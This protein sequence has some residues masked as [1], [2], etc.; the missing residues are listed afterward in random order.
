[1]KKIRVLTLS[2]PYVSAAYRQKLRF[3]AED[4]RFEIGLI[5]PKQWAGQVFEPHPE[6]SYW[7]RTLD[8]A[9]DGKNHF[10]FYRGLDQAVKEF[11]PDI[12]NIEEE[13]YSYVTWQ[14]LRLAR[15]YH[16]KPL[17]YTWQNIH[18][19]YPF[20][21]SAIERAVFKESAYAIA[22][23][24]EAEDILRAKHFKGPCAII[25]QMGADPHA[26][27]LVKPRR[28][29]LRQELTA[30]LGL[31]DSSF[32][33]IYA[34]RLVE[35]KGLTDFL[36]AIKLAGETQIHALI[37]G[38]GPQ[39]P[40]LEALAH[41]LGI[42]KQVHFLGSVSGSKI[43]EYFSVADALV[44]PSRTRKNWKEQFGRVLVEAMLCEAVPIG[45]DSGEIP[46]VIAD[47]GLVFHEG[48]AQALASCLL[49]LWQNPALKQSLAQKSFERAHTLYTNTVIARQFTD[50][51]AAI[52]GT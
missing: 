11:Q 23:N 20:P 35:E 16:A 19:R 10:H 26:I 36:E 34:G 14:C 48:D 7:L 52:A 47:A 42:S 40:A 13:H 15:K 4:P 29:S 25:P 46:H 49:K 6:D 12:F 33:A 1:M 39:R 31:T 32:M 3:W 22:G 38:S 8:I 28:Q 43:Y 51:F 30:S 50:V 44:L 17:F 18:K 2:K 21:F 37:L 9:L 5:A 24:Q 27:A 41:E 45:S